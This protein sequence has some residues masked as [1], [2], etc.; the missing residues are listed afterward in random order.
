M[1]ITFGLD[2]GTTNSALAISTPK[3]VRTVSISNR[4]SSERTLRSVLF[5]DEE[6]NVFVGQRAI[7]E[8]LQYEGAYGRFLQSIKAFL[9]SASFTSTSIFGRQYKIE[10]LVAIILR[11][12]KSAGER[13][14]G[15]SVSRVI[16]GRPVFFSEKPEDDALAESRLRTT[17][18][19]AGFSDIEFELEPI[20]ATLAYLATMRPGVEQT[21]LM[22]DFGGGTSDFTVMRL[23]AGAPMTRKEKRERILSVGGVY[24][25]GD[26]F[27]SRVMRERVT[28]YFGRDIQFREMGDRKMPMPLWIMDMLCQWHMTPM[29]RAKQTLEIIRQIKRTADDQT[30]VQ[31][32][33][34]LILEN[35]G[36]MIFQAIER[37]KKELS[38][39]IEA[40]ILYR[41]RAMHIDENVARAEFETIIAREVAKIEECVAKT[42]SDAK[43]QPEQVDV[44]LLTGGSSFVPVIR[45]LFEQRFGVQKIVNL[46]AFTSVAH[47]L[48]ISATIT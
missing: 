12:I 39:E 10:D 43:V 7:D 22:G 46:D 4:E 21:V 5:F 28:P 25:G 48:A 29:L 16:L 36:F 24:V 3:G 23:L 44:V 32:L 45:R 30:K 2:F 17:A 1:T 26:S 41:E 15:E 40:R 20:A 47:G 38:S 6:R 35:Q 37:A 18:M 27:D 34:N 19:D 11:E 9:P 31:N 13:E 8:Y 33:E 14:V 42:M